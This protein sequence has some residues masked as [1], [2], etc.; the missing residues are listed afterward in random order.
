MIKKISIGL[1]LI[2]LTSGCVS[3]KVFNELETK[4]A[5]LKKENRKTLYQIN[6]I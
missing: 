2:A 4:F 1:V 6:S 3:K 5:D